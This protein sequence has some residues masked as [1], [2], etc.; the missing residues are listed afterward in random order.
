MSLK[1]F[2]CI[3]A[4]VASAAARAEAR[5]GGE[6][7]GGASECNGKLVDFYGGHS[8]HE[9]P[10]FD[11][12]IETVSRFVPEWADARQKN[13]EKKNVFLIP[14]KLKPLP[15]EMTDLYF[16]TG[17]PCYQTQRELVCETKVMRQSAAAATPRFVHELAVAGA[18]EH[19]ASLADVRAAV[20]KFFKPDANYL[21][22]AEALG[23]RR[24]ANRWELDSAELIRLRALPRFT[25]TLPSYDGP[26]TRMICAPHE[27]WNSGVPPY[28]YGPVEKYVWDRPI[29]IGKR[30]ALYDGFVWDAQAYVTPLRDDP[31]RWN[32]RIVQLVRADQSMFFVCPT[33]ARAAH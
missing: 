17:N 30:N 22:I 7:G 4:L 33:G 21:E 2:L 14:C 16:E 5:F 28:D 20:P 8:V 6:A 24:L 32:Y 12:A 18:I 15:G 10:G 23:N 27:Y 26:G 19:G 9:L 3:T 25:A 29:V 13:L 11:Q 31:Q 1:R